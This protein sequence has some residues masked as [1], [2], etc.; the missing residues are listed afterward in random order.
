MARGRSQ[1]Q[2]KYRY[3]KYKRYLPAVWGL[4]MYL[5]KFTVYVFT[6]RGVAVLEE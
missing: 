5:L 6:F 3:C 2:A 1:L 4:G